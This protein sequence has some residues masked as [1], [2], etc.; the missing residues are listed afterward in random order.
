[1]LGAEHLVLRDGRELG[2]G[3][4]SAGGLGVL[5]ERRRSEHGNG[6]RDQCNL[7]HVV[8]QCRSVV[9]YNAGWE[10]LFPLFQD[11]ARRASFSVSRPSSDLALS[12]GSSVATLT[13]GSASASRLPWL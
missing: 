12:C 13:T 1:Q 10:H 5:S 9:I 6:C 8:L 3:R 11:A 4:R 2:G 7:L